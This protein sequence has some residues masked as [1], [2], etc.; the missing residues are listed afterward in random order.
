MVLDQELGTET[1]VNQ[2]S[3]SFVADVWTLVAL[4]VSNTPV[5]AAN[6][7]SKN[8]V[9]GA[10]LICLTEQPAIRQGGDAKLRAWTSTSDGRP[11]N[12]QIDL[13]WEVD[14][15]RIEAQTDFTLWDLSKV[16]VAPLKTLKVIATVRAAPPGHNELRCAV[17]V[18]IGRRSAIEILLGEITAVVGAGAGAAARLSARQ[19][20]LPG[21][22][23]DPG[24]GLYSYLLFSAPP[25]DTEE[26][27]RYLKTIEAYLLVLQDVDS[28]LRLHVRPENLNAT[29]IPLKQLPD[30]GNSN[31]ERAANVLAAYDY[32][33]AQILLSKV[34]S[35][36]QHGPYLVSVLQPLSASGARAY[37]WED[38]TGVVPELAWNWVRFFTYL[39]AQERTWSEESLQRFGLKL[40]NL[41]AVGGK[42]TPDGLKALEKAVQFRRKE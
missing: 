25:K 34:H 31:A 11:L 39:A 24:Y 14:A 6:D 22:A 37:L 42:V 38:L 1:S 19:Y 27:A 20:L 3:Q 41:V 26:N 33:A 32:A 30:A 12:T 4:L 17:E 18:I 40:R 9:M 2:L 10:E 23:E 8:P 7:P 35:A 15:G 21:V 36:Y 13:V 29:Y 16:E 5:N 28:Y